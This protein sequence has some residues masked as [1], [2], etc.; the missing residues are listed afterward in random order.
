M[1]FDIDR[2]DD[3]ANGGGRLTRFVRPRDLDAALGPDED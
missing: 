3:I 2:W 1:T